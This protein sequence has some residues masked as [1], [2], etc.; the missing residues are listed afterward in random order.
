M[1]ACRRLLI[2]TIVSGLSAVPLAAIGPVAASSTVDW[3][4]GG[5]RLSVSVP[6]DTEAAV[7]PAERR[8]AQNAIERALPRLLREQLF[9][10]IVDSYRTVGD[11]AVGDPRI[12]SGLEDMWKTG[13]SEKS[14]MAPSLTSLDEAYRYRFYPHLISLFIRHTK[15]YRPERRLTHAPADE[16][17]GLVIYAKGPL[18][19]R[20]IQGENSGD[21]LVP[22]LFTRI[23]DRDMNLVLER[24]SLDPAVLTRWGMA[25]YTD[26]VDLSG[27]GDRVGDKPLFTAARELFGEYRTDIIISDE[28][29]A[30][31]LA[32]ERN[33]DMITQGRILIIC[34]L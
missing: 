31:I 30:A 27:Y 18:P 4:E 26:S 20:G 8:T 21:V 12:M 7:L 19:V 6:L 32:D 24:E 14:A 13:A 15:G 28:A 1:R 11:L 16:Y 22:A 17:T 10:V 25:A 3:I 2:M 29:A 34:D 23:F 5:L 9:P 33:I